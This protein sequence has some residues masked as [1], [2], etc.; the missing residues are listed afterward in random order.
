MHRAKKILLLVAFGCAALCLYG[1]RLPR[2]QAQADAPL[3][4][5][6]QWQSRDYAGNQYVGSRAC[7]A[8]HADKVTTQKDTPMA[9]A[10]EPVGDVKVLRTNPRLTF[11]SGA[12]RYQVLR[13]G[14]RATYTVSDGVTTISEPIPYSFGLGRVGQTYLFR[15]NGALYESRVTYYESLRGLDFT[16]GQQQMVSTTVEEALGRRLSAEDARACFACHAPSAVSGSEL[17][18]EQFT[19]GVTC[20][21]C[22]GPGEKHIAAIK[23]G[24]FDD[25]QIFNP[26]QLDGISL[27]QEF[28]GTCH[29]G[30]GQVML[31]PAQGGANN[32]RFQPYRIFNSRGH[33]KRDPRIS[34]IACHN[35]HQEI[36][37]DA[38]FYDA[39][40]LA[41]HLADAKE[42]KTETRTAAA[43]PVGRQQCAGC[44]MP[45]L[46]QPEMHA[47]FTDHW[48]RVVKPG[49]P[50]PK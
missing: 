27:S 18:L 49:A 11:R 31:L 23:A 16:G 21:S 43:C 3:A 19:P 34:C 6:S 13:E 2:P 25:A 45:K 5:L 24:Q 39:K 15:H 41:C 42:A 40:C 38:A 36:R 32:I 8:C 37:R 20:E 1:A 28:C 17:Q 50:V 9:H 22:H 47:K 46:E 14:D 33:N 12:Y 29:R 35:P 10:L 4:R 44:H 48:I 7:A 26:G 30:F